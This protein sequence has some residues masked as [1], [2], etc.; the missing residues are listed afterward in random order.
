LCKSLGSIQSITIQSI[1]RQKTKC[2]L[3]SLEKIAKARMKF[4]KNA[5]LWLLAFLANMY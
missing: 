3:G 5:L 2:K 1:F 4:N